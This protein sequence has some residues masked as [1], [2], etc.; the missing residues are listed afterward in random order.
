MPLPKKKHL[1]HLKNK[2]VGHFVKW[3]EHKV[4]HQRV[5][6]YI[7]SLIALILGIIGMYQI[8]IS[9]NLLEDMPQKA[10]FFEDIRFFDK[11]FN[12]I[13]PIEILVDSK[14]ENGIVKPATLKRMHELQENILEIKELAPAISVVNAVKFAKQAY[15]NGNPN[16]YKIPTPQE[17][18][19]IFRVHPQLRRKR[20]LI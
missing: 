2:N 9:G 1:K 6:V 15:Y 8:K 7:I 3:M 16:Y 11:S 19:F 4:R 12:G 20:K 14:R 5:N 17:N 13:I 10:A 18:S